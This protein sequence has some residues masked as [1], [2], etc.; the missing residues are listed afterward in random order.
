MR[1]GPDEGCGC[2]NLINNCVIGEAAGKERK[3]TEGT[4]KDPT[5]AVDSVESIVGR[6]KTIPFQDN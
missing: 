6:K 2:S 4:N 1:P 3:E 5:N